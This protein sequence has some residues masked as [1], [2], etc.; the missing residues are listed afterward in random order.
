M[1]LAKCLFRSGGYAILLTKKR[2]LKH[3]AMFK[4]KTLVRTRHGSRDESHRCC[5]QMED[6]CARE[7]E[8]PFGEKLAQIGVVPK[9]SIQMHSQTLR[10]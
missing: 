5:T 10:F 4:C 9:S 1:I 8:F 3:R 7:V 2:E 6:E